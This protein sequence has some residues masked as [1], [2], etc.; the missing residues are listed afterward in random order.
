MPNNIKAMLEQNY[1]KIAMGNIEF[2][3]DKPPAREVTINMN[4]TFKPSKLLVKFEC[5]GENVN[6]TERYIKFDNRI[7]N[8]FYEYFSF[9]RDK[10]LSCYI[11]GITI[12]EKALKF[13][14][15]ID[16]GGYF[17]FTLKVTEWIAIE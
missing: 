1:K 15:F 4:L 7:T 10:D 16:S 11:Y 12:T 8:Y 13:G 17:D 9:G 6:E 14:A 3:I 2:F 5:S